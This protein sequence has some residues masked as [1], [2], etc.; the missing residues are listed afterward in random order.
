[1]E[2]QFLSAA[3]GYAAQGFY[4]LPLKPKSKIPLTP[5]GFKDASNDPEQIK[6]WWTRWPDANIGIATGEIS[7]VIVIDLDDGRDLPEGWPVIDCE[8]VV[9]TVKGYHLYFKY[10][11]GHDI[12]SRSKIDGHDVDVR[13]NGGYIVAPP[14]IH[15]DGGRY[16]FVTE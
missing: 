12:R 16:E 2:N 8:C 9:K 5:K 6:Q 4:V 14:S 15:P 7:G 1:M 3:L 11:D 13:G 10:P